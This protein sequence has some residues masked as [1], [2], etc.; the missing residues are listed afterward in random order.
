MK[1]YSHK[2]IHASG[3]PLF[4]VESLRAY[5][6]TKRILKNSYRQIVFVKSVKFYR[7][8]FYIRQLGDCFR[9]PATFEH[10]ICSISNKSTQSQL[11]VCLRPLQRQAFNQELGYFDKHSPTT[12]DRK[13]PQRKVSGF[14]AWKVLN[15]SF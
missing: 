15:I 9:F 5:S 2:Y 7:I 1:K 13:V 3:S 12:W 10:I 11:T 6:F 8:S 4:T 14:F